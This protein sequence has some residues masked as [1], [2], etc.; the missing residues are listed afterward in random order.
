[1]VPGTMF[2][3]GNDIVTKKLLSRGIPERLL[4]SFAWGGAGAVYAVIVFLVGAPVIKPAFWTAFAITS[5]LNI[6]GQ[7]A[8]YRAFKAGEV[9][10]VAPLRLL[11]PILVIGTAFLF[12]REVPG[13]GGVAGILVTVLGLRFL[14]GTGGSGGESFLKVLKSPTVLWGILGAVSF[15]FSFPF[16]KKSVVSSSALFAAC[17]IYLAVALGSFLMY[18]LVDR[19]RGVDQPSIVEYLRSS[20]QLILTGITL[21][22]AGGFLVLYALNFTLA[23]YASS[24][25]RLQALWSVILSGSLLGEGRIPEKLAAT[26]IMLLGVGIT[27]FFG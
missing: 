26:G 19:K 20:W 22:S 14:L 10:L 2:L 16:D 12:L 6:F 13:W 7:Y 1:M 3:S 5:V 27:V 8:W 17:L 23:A 11:I 21:L 15:A 9:S 24:V 18:L 4:L 25:K